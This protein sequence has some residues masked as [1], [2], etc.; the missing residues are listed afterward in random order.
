[1]KTTLRN[2][3]LVLLAFLPLHAAAF[4]PQD[5]LEIKPSFE[6]AALPGGSST[7][8]HVLVEIGAL[9]H[10]YEESA[11]VSVEFPAGG[12]SAGMVRRPKGIMK[13]DSVSG[14]RMSLYEGKQD[15]TATVSVPPDAKAGEIPVRILVDYQACTETLCFFPTQDTVLTALVVDPAAPPVAA[16]APTEPAPLTEGETQVSSE[17]GA[18]AR[19]LG[20][21]LPTALGLLWVFGLIAS[22]TPCVL[23]MI[24][25]TVRIITTT[26]GGDRKKG[27]VLSIVYVLGIAATYV[28][29]GVSAGVFGGLFGAYLG[30]P[31]VIWTLIVFFVALGL[32]SFGFYKVAL[33]SGLQQKLNTAGGGASTVGVFVMGLAG[34]L[35]AAPCVG[36]V[37]AGL[38]LWIGQEGSPALG[39]LY[40]SV[41]SL[42][43]GTLFLILGAGGNALM[44]KTGAW[45]VAV[46]RVLGTLLFAGALYFLNQVVEPVTFAVVSGSLLVILG[47]WMAPGKDEVETSFLLLRSGCGVLVTAIGLLAVLGTMATE[48]WLLTR[49]LGIGGGALEQVHE[50]IAWQAAD[51]GDVDAALAAG[52]PILID[53]TADWCIAC[54]ELDKFTFSDP[55]VVQEAARFTAMQIDCTRSS[56][57]S[58]KAIQARFAINSL[59]TVLLIDAQGAINH[60]VTVRGFVD[61]EEFLRRLRTIP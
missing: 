44:P 30:N 37:L 3:A 47:R 5:V 46:E 10:L 55:A 31:W 25:I 43:F 16:A 1:M 13:I 28:S 4:G 42:G 41:F 23:P 33:P 7:E 21:S 53:F 19:I 40:M 6:P 20:E 2:I 29:L 22:F 54:K 57:P 12:A 38:I 32:S 36:P 15:F 34:G 48:G 35:I 59:P 14:E 24:P 45:M 58:I 56:E 17:Y 27:V 61:A 18:F 9:Y 8:L 39:A 52:K 26:S 11:G 60:E 49:P 51:E 50:G